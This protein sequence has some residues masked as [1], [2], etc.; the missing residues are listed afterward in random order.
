MQEVLISLKYLIK[1]NYR[2]L[3]KKFWFSN[4]PEPSDETLARKPAFF[5]FLPSAFGGEAKVGGILFIS[6][7]SL[8]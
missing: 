7:G 2:C 5:V 1:K 4:Q 6:I 8:V 3:P